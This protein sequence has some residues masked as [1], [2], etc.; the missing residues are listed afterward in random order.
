MP[1]RLLSL[2]CLTGAPFMLACDR[3]PMA[4][5][6]VTVT[7]PDSVPPV[8]ASVVPVADREISGPTA[9]GAVLGMESPEAPFRTLFDPA[10]ASVVTLAPVVPA[11]TRR[12]DPS[13]YLFGTAA[14]AWGVQVGPR[15]DLGRKSGLM[16]RG[17][18][19]GQHN[20][21]DLGASATVGDQSNVQGIV[22]F[23]P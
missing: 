17:G 19:Q 13:M 9:R 10:A 23:H 2:L 12:V 8:Q 7:A 20:R 5:E 15:T 18:T 22:R 1:G 21:W 4:A 6:A 14:D 16:L 11:A 3:G